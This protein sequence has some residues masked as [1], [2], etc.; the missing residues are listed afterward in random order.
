MPILM[1]LNL[2]EP[3][4]INYENSLQ[5][6]CSLTLIS[7]TIMHSYVLP[8]PNFFLIW[9]SIHYSGHTKRDNSLFLAF[10]WTTNRAFRVQN[11]HNIL[12]CNYN[13][14][15]VGMK[16]PTDLWF[17]FALHESPSKQLCKRWQS[18]LFFLSYL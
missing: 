3:F 9:Q 6:R 16:A 4:Y 18:G 12:K 13:H 15:S 10:S 14:N 7:T 17:D 5:I 1:H 11:R 2:P 8:S